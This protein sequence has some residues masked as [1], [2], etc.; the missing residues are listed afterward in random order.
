MDRMTSEEFTL[1]KAFFSLEPWGCD[2][3][4]WRMGMV[5]ATI[6]NSAPRG[7]KARAF[8]PGDFYRDPYASKSDTLTPEQREFIKKRKKVKRG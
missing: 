7:E 8:K 4:N 1:W 2:V 5:A 3:E 6:V